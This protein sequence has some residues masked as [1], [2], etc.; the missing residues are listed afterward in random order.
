MSTG[1][2]YMD[3]RFRAAPNSK[4]NAQVRKEKRRE[5]KRSDSGSGEVSYAPVAISMGLRNRAPSVVTEGGV[6]KITHS[7]VFAAV[8]STG[9]AFNVLSF[10]VNP[11]LATCFPWLAPVAARYE[12]YKFRRLEFI[13]RTQAATTQTGSVCLA[14]DFD[15]CDEP[16]ETY[17]E[18]MAYRDKS[19]SAPWGLQKL[20]CD[21]RQGDRLPSKYTRVGALAG[22]QDLK[23]YDVG[24]LHVG[25]EG[26]AAATVGLLEVH[27]TVD[28]YTP[29][30]S[31]SVGG[32]MKDTDG[33][34][35]THVFG[36][37]PTYNEY[38]SLPGT[39]NTAGQVFTFDQMWEGLIAF[40]LT[41]TG[42]SNNWNPV[43][44]ASGSFSS[45][46]QA[47]NAAGTTVVGYVYGRAVPGTTLTPTVT[48][49]T[50]TASKY[51]FASASARS[52]YL[53]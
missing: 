22:G 47:V 12:T 15:A 31:D 36:T 38:S 53:A 3:R 23:T 37:S 13:F 2:Q 30:M 48:A 1:I 51:A 25:M 14:F 52:L 26:V 8:A 9:A 24:T 5:G 49:T 44:S 19:L 40:T 16:P 6:C 17:M 43:A 28:L 33:L 50:V 35:A 7:E 45:I 29:Q 46:G 34:D 11:G 10:S 39:V 42:L 18:A 41:G 4:G 20:V 32:V 21:L 27:Y